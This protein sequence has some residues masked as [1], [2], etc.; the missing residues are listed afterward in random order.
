MLIEADRDCH[1]DDIRMLQLFSNVVSRLCDSN[2]IIMVYCSLY[3][4]VK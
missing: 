4:Y 2:V 1:F 3:V